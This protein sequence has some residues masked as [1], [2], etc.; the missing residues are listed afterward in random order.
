MDIKP[1]DL[2]DTFLGTATKRIYDE[3]RAKGIE[4]NDL[5]FVPYDQEQQITAVIKENNRLLELI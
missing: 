2:I 3:A 4:V 5:V 1:S